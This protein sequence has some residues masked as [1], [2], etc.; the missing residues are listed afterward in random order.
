MPQPTWFGKEESIK[1]K[2]NKREA[3]VYKHLVSGALSQKG[4][5]SNSS[6]VFDNKSTK[7]LSIRV[8]ENMCD[9]LLQDAL[10]MGKENAVLILDLPNYYLTCKVQKKS[11]L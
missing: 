6:T 10:T 9:K 8:T 4:D 2:A 1:K 5:F 7:H 3:K 11:D